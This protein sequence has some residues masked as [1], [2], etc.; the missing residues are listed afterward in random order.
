MSEPY[1]VCGYDK[2]VD[3]EET[4]V[5]AGNREIAVLTAGLL[6]RHQM[7]TDAV[8]SRSGEP[9]DWFLLHENGIPVLR[10]T[11]L[12]PDGEELE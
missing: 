11:S 1:T 7:K 3:T 8:R 10:F 4:L 9:F 5:S 12:H 2:D 6:M